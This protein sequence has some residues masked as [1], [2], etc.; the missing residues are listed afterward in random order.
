MLAFSRPLEHGNSG[1]FRDSETVCKRMAALVNVLAT[2]AEPMPDG[3]GYILPSSWTKT[4]VKKSE[5]RIELN[6]LLLFQR[7]H[8][9]RCT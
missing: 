6:L 8:S 7:S 2:V 4:Y 5:C 3:K 1:R 9:F